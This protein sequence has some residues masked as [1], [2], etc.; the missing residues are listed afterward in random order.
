MEVYPNP[1]RTQ[2]TIGFTLPEAG[3]A[4]LAVFDLEGRQVQRLVSGELAAGEHEVRWNGR[5]GNN[6]QMPAGLYLIRLV[7]G[8]AVSVQRVMLQ[9]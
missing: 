4:T 6:R 5:N 8:D 7:S 2:L 3:A 1:F 9:H